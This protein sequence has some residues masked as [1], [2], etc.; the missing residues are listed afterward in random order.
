[1]VHTIQHFRALGKSENRYVL[2]IESCNGS[3]ESDI[4]L[5]GIALSYFGEDTVVAANFG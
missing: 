3:E 5:K 1:M 2:E 4:P